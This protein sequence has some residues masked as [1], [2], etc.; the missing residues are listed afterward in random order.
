MLDVLL[1]FVM[2]RPLQ[3]RV[4]SEQQQF[5]ALRQRILEDK[6]RIERLEEFREALPKAGESLASFKRDHAPPRRQGFSRAAKLVR[7]ATEQAGTQLTSVA[8]K[9]DNST[10]GP[11]ERLGLVINVAGPFAGLLKFAHALETASDFIVIQS[12]S[13]APGG[14]GALELRLAAELYL[15]P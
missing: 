14:S 9:L 10:S 13:I 2:F 11:L 3:A 7:H 8:Y 12:F 1:Y 4:S 15:T 6:A 5:V